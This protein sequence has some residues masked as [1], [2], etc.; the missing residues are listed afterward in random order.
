MTQVGGSSLRA[1]TTETEG[2]PLP[3]ANWNQVKW[4]PRPHIVLDSFSDDAHIHMVKDIYPAS[5]RS[6]PQF[7]TAIG[8]T[9][10]FSAYD[11]T[12]GRELWKSDGTASGTMMVKDINSV[13]SS[14]PGPFTA[15]GNTLYFQA[16]DGTNGTELWKS[17]GTHQAR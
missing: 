5:G 8:S 4:T 17:D 3:T 2:A 16:T 11:T 15:V 14:S 7:F 13:G 1:W 12:F 6:Y 10:Y 9:L